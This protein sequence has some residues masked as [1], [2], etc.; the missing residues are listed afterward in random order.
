MNKLLLGN[1]Q[2][3]S[4][5]EVGGGGGRGESEDFGD[6]MVFQGE[7]RRGSVVTNRV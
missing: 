1:S 7:L 4:P 5:S 3:L 6:H 2:D